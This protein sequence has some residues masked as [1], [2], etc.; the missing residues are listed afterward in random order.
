MLLTAL[1]L[2]N[3]ARQD[4]SGT[5]IGD[6]TETALFDLAREKGFDSE[7]LDERFPGW[8]RSPLTRNG[9]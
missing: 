2:S 5:V 6:P 3:D 9:S 1:A 4:A 7:R 8:P